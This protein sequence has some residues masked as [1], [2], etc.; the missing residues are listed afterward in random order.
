MTETLEGGVAGAPGAEPHLPDAVRQ[1]VVALVAGALSWL[2][3]DEI[4]QTLKKIARFAPNRRARLG[5]PALAAQVEADPVFRQRIAKKV[6]EEAGELG[7]A[8]LAGTCPASADPVEVAALA[9]LSRPEGWLDLVEATTQAVQAGERSAAV[10]GRIRDAESRA[11]RAEHEKHT[12]RVELDKLKAELA[13]LRTENAQLKDDSRALAR[14]LAEAERKEKR[15]SELL[16][17]EKGRAAKAVADHDAEIRRMRAKLA[18]AEGA[19]ETAR[20][21]GRDAR[22]LGDARTWLLLETISQAAQGLRRELSLEPADR[23]PAD[24][25]A[26]VAADLPERLGT[27]A[28]ALEASDPARLDQLLSLPRAHMIVDGYNVTKA[29][30]GELSLEQQRTRLVTGLGGIAAQTGAEVTCVFDGAERIHGLPPTPRGVRVL[31]SKKG[32]TA[33]ELIRR[34]VRAEP[35]GRPVVVISTDREVA[36]G[37]R[38]HG[39]YPL[40]SD[41]LLRRLKR[42]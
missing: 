28:R 25:V 26:D 22:A 5:G 8:L 23:L 9:Y 29:G 24:F 36:D 30:F 31:F 34:L 38:R 16:S 6:L 32:E 3:F 4:P 2:P 12:T 17:T 42:A 41:T 35:S 21:T 14:A 20:H 37:V 40:S 13:R 27:S 1:R 39:A 11:Q 7:E 15:A 33:D 18:D 19:L 10:E